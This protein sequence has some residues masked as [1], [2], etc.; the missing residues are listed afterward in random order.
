M[1]SNVLP[2]QTPKKTLMEHCENQHNG[3]AQ[4]SF[5]RK[6][7]GSEPESLNCLGVLDPLRICKKQWALQKQVNA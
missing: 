3:Q 6:S 5:P 4:E 2:N 7:D 1:A